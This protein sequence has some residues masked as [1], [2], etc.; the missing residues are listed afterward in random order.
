MVARVFSAV[1]FFFAKNRRNFEKIAKGEFFEM[2]QS[3]H[4]S[5]I[6]LNGERC[7]QKQYA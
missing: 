1:K 5:I 4:E 2:P 6:W 3:F 7:E